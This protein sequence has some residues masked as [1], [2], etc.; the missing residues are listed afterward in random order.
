MGTRQPTICEIAKDTYAI[1]EFGMAAMFLLVG[2]E[3]AMLIDTGCSLVD[4]KGIVASL[5]DKPCMVVLTHGHGDHSAGVGQFDE[6][7]MHPADEDQVT[8]MNWDFL[9]NY[10][11]NFITNWNSNVIYDISVD[12]V[13]VYDPPK[14]I[15]HLMGGEVIDLGDRPITVLFTPGHTPG[16]ISFVDHKTRI[17]FSG[18]ACNINLGAGG[19]SVTTLLAAM[20]RIKAVE[21][22]FDRNYNGH[23]G[24]GISQTIRSMPDHVLDTVIGICEEVLSGK[25]QPEV[26]E[27]PFG[28]SARVERNG[29]GVTL[30]PTR[31]CDP[32]ET[33]VR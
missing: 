31:L 22:Q 7:W 32:D 26:R 15:H 5:T 25:L 2:S 16:G 30:D 19:S 28:K 13:K 3:K 6:V 10:V 20:D 27:T 24:Y 29:V 11:A 18:D 1:N 4:L 17:L 12:D 21:D 33:P 14:T 8:N 23:I 9:K